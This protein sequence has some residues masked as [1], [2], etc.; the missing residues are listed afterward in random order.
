MAPVRPW[1]VWFHMSASALK[2]F[3]YLRTWSTGRGTTRETEVELDRGFD[4]VPATLL[5]PEGGRGGLPGWVVLHGIT[6]PGRAHPSLLRFAR[7]L[8]SSGAMVLIP[9]VPEWRELHLA[10]DR[11]VPT[12]RAA[13]LAL[14]SRPE[15]V[16][17]RTGVIG[18]SFGAPQALIAAGDAEVERHLAAAVGFGGYC[19]LRSTLAFQFTGEVDGFGVKERLRPD[20]Y[21]RWVVGANYL[22]AVPGLEGAEEV[23]TALRELAAVAGEQRIESWDPVYDPLKKRLRE[24]MSPR[25][26]T[27][28][29]LFA[30]IGDAEP[31]RDE[32]LELSEALCVAAEARDPYLSPRSHVGSLATPVHLVHGR[33][34]H[35]VPFTETLR[36]REALPSGG[37][38]VTIT[39]LFAHSE[40]T[41]IGSAFHGAREGLRFF[42]ALQRILGGV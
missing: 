14:D 22:T 24:G 38:T 10:P 2:A 4:R 28:F 16:P 12:I 13:I 36:L 15:T 25:H 18:F 6:R 41:R 7:A 20:P 9:E 8:T 33:Q 35:L 5:A 30:P 32:A 17:G 26:R 40:G 23:A 34:D 42:R 19:D 31:P 27:V 29:D 11:A 1:G 39:R 37:T 21:G 3:R